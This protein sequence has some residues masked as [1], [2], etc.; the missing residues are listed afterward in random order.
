MQATI[1]EFIER[2]SRS[3]FVLSHSRILGGSLRIIRALWS[4]VLP[5]VQITYIRVMPRMGVCKDRTLKIIPQRSAK[6]G[7]AR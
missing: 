2:K 4:I 3:A 6:P 7:L 1:C 5:F